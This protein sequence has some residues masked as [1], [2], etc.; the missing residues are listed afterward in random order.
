MIPTTTLETARL[1]LRPIE[2]ADAEQIQQEFPRWEIV[3]YLSTRVPWPYPPDGALAFIRDVALPSTA[4]GEGW[5]WTLR[6]KS[7]LERI[8]GGIDLYA[9]ER[10]NRGFWLIP[11]LRGCGLMTEAADAATEFWFEVLK[12][13]VLRTSKATA[14]IAS[15]RVS[16]KQGMRMIGRDER[17]YV[18][19]RLATEIWEI[20]AEEWRARKRNV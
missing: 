7:D 4:R 14:N 3:R 1:L 2:L 6:L 11:E 9:N 15:R 20:T 16:E 17:D 5:L 18:S 13:P 8:V 12:F 10:D 19:G